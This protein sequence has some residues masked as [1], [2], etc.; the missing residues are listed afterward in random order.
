MIELKYGS[1][2]CYRDVHIIQKQKQKQT[3]YETNVEQ[4]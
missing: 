3:T 1:L 4:L 2:G